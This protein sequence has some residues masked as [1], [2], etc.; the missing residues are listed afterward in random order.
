VSTPLLANARRGPGPRSRSPATSPPVAP[1]Q[2]YRPRHMR[3]RPL[4]SLLPP[5]DRRRVRAARAGSPAFRCL[6]QF[7]ATS[8]PR[9]AGRGGSSNSLGTL[10]QRGGAW[11]RPL[12]DALQDAFSVAVDRPHE[13]WLPDLVEIRHDQFELFQRGSSVRPIPLNLTIQLTLPRHAWSGIPAHSSTAMSARWIGYPAW[14]TRR[15]LAAMSAR[16]IGYPA[17]VDA[18][19]ASWWTTPAHW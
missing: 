8:A 18:A 6:V 19:R 4:I 9:S 11:R 15:A 12:A 5:L 16:W 3:Q 14:S 1:R 10:G 7:S 13:L 17:M 2:W